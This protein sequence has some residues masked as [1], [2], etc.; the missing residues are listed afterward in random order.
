MVEN[1]RN[2]GVLLEVRL[3]QRDEDDRR[4]LQDGDEA[5]RHP[6]AYVI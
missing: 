4:R 6:A 3:F 5:Q 2:C 1:A